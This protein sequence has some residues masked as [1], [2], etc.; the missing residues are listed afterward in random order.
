MP[1][2]FLPGFA[3]PVD[4]FQSFKPIVLVPVISSPFDHQLGYFT[5]IGGPSELTEL[6][7]AAPDA[8]RAGTFHLAGPALFIE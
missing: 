4:W 3:G 8:I 5:D 1:I 7:V 6:R 2:T